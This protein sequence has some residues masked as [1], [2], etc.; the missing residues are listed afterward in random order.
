MGVADGASTPPAG[1]PETLVSTMNGADK[2]DNTS[3]SASDRQLSKLELGQLYEAVVSFI[4]G[5]A[6]AKAFWDAAP[7][8]DHS[9]EQWAQWEAVCIQLE[10][11]CQLIDWLDKLLGDLLDREGAMHLA[12][13]ERP[14]R[15]LRD[16]LID[17]RDR[18]VGPLLEPAP[19]SKGRQSDTKIDWKRRTVVA[20]MNAA[21]LSADHNKKDAGKFVTRRLAEIGR[22]LP[23]NAVRKGNA[24]ER[25]PGWRVVARWS[26]ETAS[27]AY[28]NSDTPETKLYRGLIARAKDVR[29]TPTK[30]GKDVREVMRSFVCA[31]LEEY[32]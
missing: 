27:Y 26:K 1:G 8:D 32:T 18:K 21:L 4:E 29:Q 20:A 15:T 10:Q 31:I 5:M 11:V 17:L 14:L 19:R 7:R 12:A 16:Q 24:G 23:A 6:T 13:L 22:P 30:D 9:A 28:A 2:Q 25:T 3:P